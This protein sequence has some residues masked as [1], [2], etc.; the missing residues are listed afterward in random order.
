MPVPR[1]TL[2]AAAAAVLLLGGY[3]W[4]HV[5]SE[6]MLRVAAVPLPPAPPRGD[7]VEGERLSR[8]LGCR[9][10]HGPQLRGQ[11]F[12]A[13]DYVYRL[14]A[15]DLV[16]RLPAYSDE[17]LVRLLRTGRKRDGRLGVG[18]PFKSFQ[19]M[20]DR[21]VGDLLAHLRA[22]PPSAPNPAPLPATWFSPLARA[23][24]A[25]GAFPLDRLAA[26]P[27][28]APALRAD[29]ASPNR[30]RRLAQM[31][32]GECHGVDFAG[33]PDE[34]VPPLAIAAAYSPEA[35][36]V[37]LR[38]GRTLSGGDSASGE[39]SRTSR[40]RLQALSAEEIAQIHAAVS[41]PPQAP[42]AP[43]RSP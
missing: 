33:D 21:E 18:M 13:Q 3:A 29:R 40:N 16:E 6:S 37:L 4:I 5:R 2:F 24:L 20:T 34:A 35:F 17:E 38:T 22:L 25:F 8:I 39:M 41:A 32:C 7:A 10:C 28:D 36:A 23:G 31:A 14:V 42:G 12:M 9:D 15:P 30:G 26:D 43:A 1:W 19:R 27:V 11:V